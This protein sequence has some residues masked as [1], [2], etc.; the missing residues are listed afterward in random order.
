M[1]LPTENLSNGSGMRLK[2][3]VF[4]ASLLDALGWQ[5]SSCEN[6]EVWLSA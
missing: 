4:R 6:A 5:Y 2:A 3:E 1:E